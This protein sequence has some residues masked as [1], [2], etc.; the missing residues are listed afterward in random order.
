MRN[1]S[2]SAYFP[3]NFYAKKRQETLIQVFEEN[4]DR[5]KKSYIAL[6]FMNMRKKIIKTVGRNIY[7][8]RKFPLNL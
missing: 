1:H 6:I 2:V 3:M 5:M 8:L 4:L 7:I